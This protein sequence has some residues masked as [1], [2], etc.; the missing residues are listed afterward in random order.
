MEANIWIEKHRIMHIVFIGKK[1]TFNV[2]KKSKVQK[3]ERRCRLVSKISIGVI[4]AQ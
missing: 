2:K 3:D 1:C 4:I